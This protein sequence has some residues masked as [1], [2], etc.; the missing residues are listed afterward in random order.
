MVLNLEDTMRNVVVDPK[1]IVALDPFRMVDCIGPLHV[2]T[3]PST[4]MKQV[5]TFKMLNTSIS[6][7]YIVKVSLKN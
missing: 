7:R 6:V 4:G 2:E 1:H 3:V 5:A